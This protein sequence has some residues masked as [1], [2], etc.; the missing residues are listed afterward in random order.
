MQER[1]WLKSGSNGDRQKYVSQRKLVA[2][3]VKQAI[4]DWLQEKARFVEVGM[5][6]GSY[7]G[8][9]WQSIQEM[10]KGTNRIETSDN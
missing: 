3:A 10:Q 1:R 4:N 6:S 7:S 9:A 8:L 5:L 2:G